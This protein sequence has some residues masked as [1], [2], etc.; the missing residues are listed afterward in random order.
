MAPVPGRM[1][2]T[3]LCI[4]EDLTTGC[5]TNGR[6]PDGNRLGGGGF[7]SAAS[8]R[9]AKYPALRFGGGR[10]PRA[11]TSEKYYRK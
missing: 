4:P 8:A 10:V 3:P 9:A 2:Q 11:G 5:C 7:Y 1:A 6:K